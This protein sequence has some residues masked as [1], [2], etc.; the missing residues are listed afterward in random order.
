MGRQQGIEF[1]PVGATI[2]NGMD[3]GGA[4]IYPLSTS[5]AISPPSEYS[6]YIGT[7]NGL[8]VT[9]PVAAQIGSTGTGGSV[10]SAIAAVQAKPF[11]PDSPLPWLI[12][13]LFGA[14]IAMHFI[15][16]K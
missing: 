12:A 8:P 16:Y 4:R 5:F 9:P 7:G 1:T 13:G 6:N 3:L 14:V 10:S 11:G 2:E 15:H